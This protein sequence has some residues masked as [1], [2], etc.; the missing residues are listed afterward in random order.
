V[1]VVQ[2]SVTNVI[3]LP[4]ETLTRVLGTMTTPSVACPP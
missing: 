1:K 3:G 2:G 4:M